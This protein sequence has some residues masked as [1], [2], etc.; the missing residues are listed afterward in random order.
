M[1]VRKSG[2]SMSDVVPQTEV[3]LPQ[4]SPEVSA[5]QA[6]RTTGDD[7][8]GLVWRGLI[9]T[10]VS[11]G[12]YR[13]WYRTDLRRWYWRNTIVG[14]HAL[15]YRGT[16]R[17]LFVGFLIALTVVLPLYFSGSLVAL[18]AGD[19]LGNTITGL[20]GLIFAVLVQ[21]GAYRSR[22][23]RLTRTYWRGVR[24]DQQGS[25][26]RYAAISIFWLAMTVISIGLLFPLFRRALE[27]YRVSNTWFGTAQGS[28]T[29]KIG[30]IMQ[31]W[32]ILWFVGL[33]GL[34]MGI[35]FCFIPM[36]QMIGQGKTGAAWI[37]G[38]LGLVSILTPVLLWPV[39]RAAEFRIFTNGSAI[40]DVQFF[41]CLE[42]RAYYGIFLRFTGVLLGAMF[43][44]LVFMVFAG[45]VLN[46]VG[47]MS[48]TVSSVPV[49]QIA[50]GM[51]GYLGSF[52]IF[53]GIKEL[54]L[55]QRFW[56][57]ATQSLSILNLASADSVLGQSIADEAA[58]GEGLAD[59]FDFGGV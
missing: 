51:L 36:I 26:W 34:G 31:G 33:G 14:D 35:V 7:L 3:F 12:F 48:A 44:W 5:D 47:L 1:P 22:R 19:A 24:F 17:E 11:L 9:L 42:T 37:L 49:A 29:V 32:L 38:L 56:R 21:Y 30:E 55:N 53:G 59:A 20:S 43:A 45:F 13:F 10:V 41:S 23:Y 40:G 39:Y 8:S 54:V 2:Y 6:P 46:A 25:G 28:F 4:A 18:F 27:R 50:L 57:L 16:A 15:E 58:T 52:L